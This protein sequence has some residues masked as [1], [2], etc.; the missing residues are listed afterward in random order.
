MGCQPGWNGSNH[1][2]SCVGYFAW[3]KKREWEREKKGTKFQIFLIA[4]W[5]SQYLLK[6]LLIK[7]ESE[8]YFISIYSCVKWRQTWRTV[9]QYEGAK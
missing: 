5:M 9:W 6:R 1:L 2:T 7:A 3:K 4:D 8:S